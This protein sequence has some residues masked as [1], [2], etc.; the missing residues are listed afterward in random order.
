[1]KVRDIM[2]P[3]ER[4]ISPDT[5]VAQAC[6]ELQRLKAPALPVVDSDQALLGVVTA[7]ELG[8]CA[9]EAAPRPVKEYRATAIVTA[10]PEMDVTRLAEMM[11]YKGL[12]RILVLEARRLVG[13]V[14]LADLEGAARAAAPRLG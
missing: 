1:M 4:T 7:A 13:A 3:A 5:T 10:T 6:A 14:S 11:R 2:R 9:P 12:D 8:R